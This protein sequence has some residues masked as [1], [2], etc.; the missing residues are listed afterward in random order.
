MK[1]GLSDKDLTLVNATLKTC[2]VTRAVLFGS[3][4]KGNWRDN[5]DID[6]AV[7]GNI[8]IGS[9]LEKMDELP[10]PYK[11]DIV[12]YNCISNEHLRE[13]IDRVGVEL[14]VHI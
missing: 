7:W 4:A 13:H 10:T 2:G 14:F 8:N 12:N 6:I 3:R 1:F 9:L 5:S 11:F